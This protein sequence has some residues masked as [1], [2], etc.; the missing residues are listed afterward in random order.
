[1]RPLL[2][3][4]FEAYRDLLGRAFRGVTDEPMPSRLERELHDVLMSAFA[5]FLSACELA[6]L[7]AQDEEGDCGSDSF[8]QS[9]F[10]WVCGTHLPDFKSARTCR[11][12]DA[13]IPLCVH[14]PA[15]DVQTVSLR[16]AEIRRCDVTS[17]KMG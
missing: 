12:D 9:F 15:S 5:M 16:F 4:T 2:S 1:M 3:L 10:R 8:F 7:P 17:L 14:S 6:A 13:P 11:G